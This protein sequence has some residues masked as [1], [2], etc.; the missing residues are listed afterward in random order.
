[1]GQRKMARGEEVTVAL[2]LQ[3]L[4]VGLGLCLPCSC[5]QDR[6]L[7]CSPAMAPAVH[8][9]PW[10]SQ[11]QPGFWGLP[12]LLLVD[13]A[14]M[15]CWICSQWQEPLQR[16]KWLECR[17]D[18]THRLVQSPEC[19]ANESIRWI[20][21]LQ[22]L[23]QEADSEQNGCRLG[24]LWVRLWHACIGRQWEPLPQPLS[25]RVPSLPRGGA[26]DGT[27]SSGHS[28]ASFHPSWVSLRGYP[29]RVV[30]CSGSYNTDEAAGYECRIPLLCTVWPNEIL[31]R[32]TELHDPA[33]YSARIWA[34]HN[35]GWITLLIETCQLIIISC[36][37]N[38]LG[39]KKDFVKYKI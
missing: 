28:E 17:L 18:Q 11:S 21:A 22:E 31:T 1:M 8:C 38:S 12:W 27:S 25:D 16:K 3:C 13:T 9:A 26:S 5:S 33:L 2:P 7:P 29:L 20:L 23:G 36:L 24:F 15:W 32:I 30:I 39:D 35:V 19:Q 37:P 6:G 10:G 34:R 4:G 14:L